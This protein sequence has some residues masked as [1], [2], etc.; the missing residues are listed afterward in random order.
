MRIDKQIKIIEQK[1]REVRLT[2]S[3]HKNAETLSEEV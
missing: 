3:L 1:L 2:S